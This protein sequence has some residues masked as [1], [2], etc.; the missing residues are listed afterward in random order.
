MCIGRCLILDDGTHNERHTVVAIDSNAG[1]VT[2]GT[3]TTY[4]Y[5]AISPTY[6]KL[7]LCMS[8]NIDIA[9]GTRIVMGDCKIGG[10]YIPANTIFRIIYTNNGGTPIRVRL[11]LEF[12]Y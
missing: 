5:S 2:I 8:S 9:S 6:C 4:A 3:G 1:T 10:S 12:L 11:Y 7:T